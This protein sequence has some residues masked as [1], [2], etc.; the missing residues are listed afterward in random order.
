MECFKVDA[1]ATR[2]LES[3]ANV[4]TVKVGLRGKMILFSLASLL[5]LSGITGAAYSF[6]QTPATHR[7]SRFNRFAELSSECTGDSLGLVRV[8]TEAHHKRPATA[9]ASISL[10]VPNPTLAASTS[11]SQFRSPPRSR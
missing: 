11:S 2:D 8:R 6:A 9:R 7:L 1:V 5:S 4:G 10:D 3:V